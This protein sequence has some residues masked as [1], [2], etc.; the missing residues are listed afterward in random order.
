MNIDDKKKVVNLSGNYCD[1][2]EY[3]FGLLIFYF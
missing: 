3:L 1:Y 2:D